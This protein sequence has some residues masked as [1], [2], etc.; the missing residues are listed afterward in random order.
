[1]A[2]I[3]SSPLTIRAQAK[4]IDMTI[5]D[6][7]SHDNSTTTYRLP[8]QRGKYFKTNKFKKLTAY[9]LTDSFYNTEYQPHE[10]LTVV[11]LWY[12]AGGQFEQIL[13]CSVTEISDKIKTHRQ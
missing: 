12:K 10:S 8:K 2:E 4:K 6:S 13:R 7:C 9:Y 5:P 11:N 3:D 1:M